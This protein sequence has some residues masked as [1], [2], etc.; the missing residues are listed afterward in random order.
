M[1]GN[2]KTKKKM[3]TMYYQTLGTVPVTPND[4]AHCNVDIVSLRKPPPGYQLCFVLHTY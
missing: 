1:H 2:K 4:N 3:V